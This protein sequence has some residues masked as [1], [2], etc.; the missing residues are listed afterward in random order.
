MRLQKSKTIMKDA[1]NYTLKKL[2]IA[3][4]LKIKRKQAFLY[5]IYK[6]ID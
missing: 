1:V 2:P 3:F 4:K 6:V 5:S